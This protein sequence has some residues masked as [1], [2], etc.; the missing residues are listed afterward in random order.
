VERPPQYNWLV[1][2]YPN[3]FNPSTRIHFWLK[4]DCH[5]RL[6]VYNSRG[7]KVRT[8]VNETLPIGQHDI[9]FDGTDDNGRSLASG[10][11]F[12]RMQSGKY[13][14]VRKMVLSK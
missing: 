14:R 3:P 1:G 7:Q 13:H 9:V 11:Y 6:D 8:L 10:V 4:E 12:T 5:V 2:N